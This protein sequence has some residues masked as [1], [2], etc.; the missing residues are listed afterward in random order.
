TPPGSPSR[1]GALAV[2]SRDR[3]CRPM[4]RWPPRSGPPRH[5]PRGWGRHWPGARE[6]CRCAPASRP[7]DLRGEPTVSGDGDRRLLRLLAGAARHQ[8]EARTR[9][10]GDEPR[11]PIGRPDGA[12]R[13]PLLRRSED[14]LLP[15]L[16]MWV[17]SASMRRASDSFSVRPLAVISYSMAG[18]LRS[19]RSFW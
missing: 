12:R 6:R 11:R 3:P 19:P 2:R 13:H 16:A 10:L 17:V 8:L 4:R 5:P 15:P 7:A 1:G 9:L 18:G 14:F